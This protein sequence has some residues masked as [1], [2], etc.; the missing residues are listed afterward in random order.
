M[1]KA[2]A[3]L[4]CALMV[5]SLAACG[6]SDSGTTPQMSN[7][8]AASTQPGS[9]GGQT[10]E[11]VDTNAKPASW[12]KGTITYEC[13]YAAGGTQDLVVRDLSQFAEK[14]TGN[15]HYVENI[16]GGSGLIM[17][18]DVFS[19]DADGSTAC[20]YSCTIPTA[21]DYQYFPSDLL[22]ALLKADV[23]IYEQLVPVSQVNVDYPAVFIREDESRF[24]TFKEMA[25]YI[26]A[27][28]GELSIGATG[29]SGNGG[30]M[31]QTFKNKFGWDLNDVYYD[32]TP[33]EKA[34]M[35]NGELDIMCTT[36]AWSAT[37]DGFTC[38]GYA[39]AEPNSYYPGVPT[40]KDQGYDFVATMRRGM[41]VKKGTDQAII[42]Y[43]E[44]MYADICTSQE[45]I[46]SEA[47]MNYS[48]DYASAAD[49]YSALSEAVEGYYS[50][51]G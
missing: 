3:F 7:Q 44:K 22:D 28:P 20:I 4:L 18:N 34:A 14:Y 10:A 40:I 12:P 24:T 19:R 47:K 5:L 37:S 41:F 26:E 36:V 48:V 29:A 43:M 13:G 23:Q 31:I 49:F 51:K 11:A 32:S 39:A 46:D 2:L 27:H 15:S 50:F 17:V 1:K 25:D 35:L 33:E 30:L 42:D 45:Y 38:I 6:G 21:A 8:P 9:E 16:T